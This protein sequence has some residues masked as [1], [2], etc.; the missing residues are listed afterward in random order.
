MNLGATTAGSSKLGRQGGEQPLFLAETATKG[1]VMHEL[2]HA[3]GF[4][5]EQGRLDRD[6]F[7]KIKQENIQDDKINQFQMEVGS[8]QSNY[9]YC[10]IMHYSSMAFSKNG[11]PTIECI[12]NGMTVGCPSCLGN[13]TDFSA[14]DIQG[15]D[16]F[17]S[18]VS[19][20]PC[21]T[22][23][24]DPRITPQGHFPDI[25][26]S[27]SQNAMAAFRRS[28]EL[29]TKE[30]AQIERNLSTSA[31]V[32]DI[33]HNV[34]TVKFVGAYPNFH[35]AKQGINIIGGT[36]FL[37]ATAAQWQD[38]PLAELGNPP[39]DDFAAR[40]RATQN[41]AV[42]NGYVGGFPNFFHRDYGKG[43]VCGTVLI[44]NGG[45]DWRDVSLA[46]LGNPPLDNISARMTSANDYAVRN[47]YL[48][49]FPTFYHADYGKGI[50]CGIVLIK[51]Q[52]GI[53]KDVIIMEGPK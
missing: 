36:V 6:Q 19:R 1:T 42:R 24:P 31:K 9:D 8:A 18:N 7:V 39:I 23:F 16:K 46:D 48:G 43:I 29:A 25:Y 2:M 22:N 5:H 15:I 10:S 13:R 26:P 52:A 44:G 28:A 33:S 3:A 14:D 21:K 37:K 17:Y 53:W 35:E 11:Q 27:A 40:M 41:Y 4:Y 38:V 20:F 45:A 34:V 32:G 12:Q 50:V 47:G 49:G 30:P 51:K